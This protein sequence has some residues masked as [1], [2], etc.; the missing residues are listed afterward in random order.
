MAAMVVGF[1]LQ[2]ISEMWVFFA[3]VPAFA[4]AEPWLFVTS[5]FL[6]ADLY[7]LFFNALALLFFGTY[8]ERIVGRTMFV[9][10]FLLAG[11]VG[12]LGYMFTTDNPMI[13]AIGASGA[14]YGIVGTLA[15]LT[16]FTLVF[17]WGLIPLPMV[18]AA[19]L[20]GLMDFAGLFLPSGVAH[21]AHLSGMFVGIALGMYLRVRARRYRYAF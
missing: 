7:H 21:G 12:N 15:V 10:L 16:P 17:I 20:W 4:L 5:I 2:Q 19:A 8:L 6:H 14:V 9:A 18:V 3:F 13:P 1:L 11:V